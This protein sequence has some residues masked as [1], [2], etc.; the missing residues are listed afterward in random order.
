MQ[1]LPAYLYLLHYYSLPI[2]PLFLLFP[3]S[4]YSPLPI[5]PLF[6]LFYSFG[7]GLIE[8]ATWSFYTLA[9]TYITKHI[10]YRHQNYSKSG[11]N[12]GIQPK[13]LRTYYSLNS[14]FF[15]SCSTYSS[16]SNSILFMSIRRLSVL[17]ALALVITSA[18]FNSIHDFRTIDFEY[19]LP[20]Y[21]PV[22]SVIAYL[23]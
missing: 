9:N 1:P 15:L 20:C 11:T 19:T 6:L 21:I 13:F 22:Q 3:S 4:Y 17:Q 5:I 18:G 12:I 16:T 10:I 14:S 7:L 23:F 2:I 8:Y